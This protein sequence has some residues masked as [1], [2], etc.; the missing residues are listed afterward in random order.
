PVV[1]VVFAGNIAHDVMNRLLRSIDAQIIAGPSEAGVY[2][3]GLSAS[4]SDKASA[5]QAAAQLRA[6]NRVMFAEVVI[7]SEAP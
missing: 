2:T 6:D 5:D 7:T 1:R 4:S 3:L